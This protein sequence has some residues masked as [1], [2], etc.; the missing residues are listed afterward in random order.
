MA[1]SDKSA[2]GSSDTYAA[3]GVL[4]AFLMGIGIGTLLASRLPLHKLIARLPNLARRR[5]VDYQILRQ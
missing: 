5:D 1:N 3:L 2:Q 4:L